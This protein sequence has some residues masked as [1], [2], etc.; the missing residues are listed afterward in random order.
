MLPLA[1]DWPVAARTDDQQI[2]RAAVDSKLLRRISVH[3]VHADIP[4]RQKLLAGRL[5]EVTEYNRRTGCVRSI[6]PADTTS[7]RHTDEELFRLCRESFVGGD[8]KCDYSGLIGLPG[9]SSKRPAD[10]GKPGRSLGR[11]GA[12]AGLRAGRHPVTVRHWLL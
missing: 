2:E 8:R 5:G 10:G 7:R 4:E 1:V 12:P 11:A 3:R 6:V 9:A